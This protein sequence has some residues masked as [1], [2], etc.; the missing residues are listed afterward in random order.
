M[1]A[2]RW[3][4]LREI[5]DTVRDLPPDAQDAALREACGADAALLADARSLLAPSSGATD[6]LLDGIVAD[7][8]ASLETTNPT[9]ER[10]GPYRLV[11]EIG[12][13]GMGA[14]YLA[15][16]VDGQFEQQVALKLIR[17]GLATDQFLTRFRAERQ[18]LA[19]LQ[20]PHIARLLDGGVD[21]QGRPYFALEYIE[22]EPIDRYCA[23]RALPVNE[24]LRLFLQA[25]RAV[26]YAHA[27]LVI[28]RDLKPAHILVTA[29]GQVRL[30]D[31]G[32][33]K[34]VSDDDEDGG[35]MTQLGIRAMTP[36]YASPEQVRAE[37][38]GTATDVYSLGVILY[39]LLAGAP[40]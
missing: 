37:A 9:G 5:F 27:N 38:V 16:R 29:D 25:C 23:S 4:R 6:A 34:V 22:G 14:V 13:G 8:M 3:N 1:D 12:Q 17:P 26:T 32:I 20:H 11:R 24:R 10:V 19:R 15:E 28:H 30:L 7:E 31:F 18:I 36:A 40:P 21:D 33:A 2:A 39:E 35:G